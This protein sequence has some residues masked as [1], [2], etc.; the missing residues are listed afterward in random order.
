V[1]GDGHIDHAKLQTRYLVHYDSADG[2]RFSSEVH[3]APWQAQNDAR[4][5]IQ[6]GYPARIMRVTVDDGS[7]RAEWFDL[8]DSGLYRVHWKSGGS[9]LA[10]IGVTD[11]GGRWLAPIN[12]VK[13]SVAFTDWGS[14]EHLDRVG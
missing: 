8:P 2:P 1:S 10:A 6:D 3:S 14:I 9:S 4:A 5:Y 11:D 13:P 12:W 7:P